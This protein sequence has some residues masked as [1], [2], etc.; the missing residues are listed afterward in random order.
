[1]ARRAQAPLR[2]FIAVVLAISFHGQFDN[3]WLWGWLGAYVVAQLLELWALWPFKPEAPTPSGLRASL[4]VVAIFLLATAFGAVAVPLW[5]APGSLGPAGSVLL[6]AGSILNV[7]SMSRGSPL[8]FMAGVIPYA[9][10]LMSAP[11]I[12]RAVRG[13]DPFSGPFLMAEIL[14][15]AAALLVFLAA[16]RLAESQNR[17]HA[18]LDARR[19][20]AEAQ[21]EAKSAFAAMVSHELR[22][23]LSAILAAA[24]E[25]QR[26]A[27]EPEMRDRAGLISQG[28]R[29]MRTLLD[30]LLDL[31]K[32]EAKR[33]RVEQIDFDLPLLIED[34][35]MF[36]SAES[37]RKGLSLTLD[38]A[39]TLPPRALGDPMRL[40]QI[41]NNLL[42]NAVKFTESGGIRVEAASHTDAGGRIVL[43]VCVADTGPGMGLERMARIFTPFD[44]GDDSV[45]R[46]HGGTGLGL[47]ISRELARVMGGDLDVEST[48]AQGSRFTMLVNLAVAGAAV[49]EIDAPPPAPGGGPRGGAPGPPRGG[50]GGA[51]PPRPASWW[52]T[53]MRWAGGRSVC[54]WARSAPTSP[55]PKAAIAHWTC[56]PP[57]LSISFSWT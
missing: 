9:A 48:P 14:F 42:S 1:M 45:A 26:R 34:V 23:P 33:M 32:L 3:V 47:A 30:D 12:D 44:Q 21:A 16:E 4:A 19:A 41:L 55:R 24:A 2:L 36:W 46:I 29:M 35:A 8:A 11:L 20:G 39:E 40:R 38:G 37:H 52:W 6:L 31:S 49:R 10:Y 5:L 28:G 27:S 43:K 13:S 53:T 17:T 51:P 22:T 7:L 25:I 18:D 56:S 57:K 54:C 15:L 50:V